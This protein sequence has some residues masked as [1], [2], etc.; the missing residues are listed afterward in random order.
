MS[1]FLCS[2]LSACTNCEAEIQS[3][4][5]KLPCKH[6]I[7]KECFIQIISKKRQCTDCKG[8]LPDNFNPEDFV[9]R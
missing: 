7:C 5:V 1:F 9:E 6:V 8:K 3:A 2:L 4:P